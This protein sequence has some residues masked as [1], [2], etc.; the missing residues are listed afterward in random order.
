MINEGWISI[1]SIHSRNQITQ[2][3]S[4]NSNLAVSRRVSFR[5]PRPGGRIDPAFS[6]LGGDVP[7]FQPALG[8]VVAAESASAHRGPAGTGQSISIDKHVLILLQRKEFWLKSQ[9]LMKL[10]GCDRMMFIEFDS[11]SLIFGR[12]KPNTPHTQEA[13]RT[14]EPLKQPIGLEKKPL[15]GCMPCEGCG[16]W[17]LWNNELAKCRARLCN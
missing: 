8:R 7:Q 1:I 14:L 10:V 3:T 15:P 16:W 4:N 12:K 9:E 2:I 13:I 6:A 5:W 11:R 17:N